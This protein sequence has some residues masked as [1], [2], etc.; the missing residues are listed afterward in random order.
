MA[1][2]QAAQTLGGIDIGDGAKEARPVARIFLE[3]WVG[4]LEE[5]FDAVEGC[6]YCFCLCSDVSISISL[7]VVSVPFLV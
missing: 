7:I 6:D 3:L 4:G 2:V 1:S 5:D